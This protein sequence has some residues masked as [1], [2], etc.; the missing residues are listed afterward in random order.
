MAKDP[1]RY[2]RI[3]AREIVE[4][5]SRGV[6][7]LEQGPPGKEAVGRLLRLAHTLKG[8]AHVVK[9]AG[10]AGLAHQLEDGLAPYASGN[11]VAS[12]DAE[13]MLRLVDGMAEQ[14]A[15]FPPAPLD[16]SAALAEPTAVPVPSASSVSSP[17]LSGNGTQAAPPPSGDEV[18][19]TVRVDLGDMDVLLEGLAETGVKLAGVKAKLA[20]LEQAADL[21]ALQLNQ[22]PTG[23]AGTGGARDAVAW[24]TGRSIAEDLHKLLQPLSRT[25]AAEVEQ[26]EREWALARD[27]ATQLRLVPA[28]AVF[29]PLRHMARETANALE[30]RVEFEANGGEHRL[31]AHVLSAMRDALLQIVR[32]AVAHGIETPAERL[33]AGKPA[34]GR[35]LMRVQ[36]RGNRIAFACED[37]GRGFDVARL[38][39]AGVRAGLLSETEAAAL[40]SEELFRLLLRGGI[41]TSEKV[42]QMAGRGLGLGVVQEAVSRL[43]AEI[44]LR[45]QPGRGS[46][47]EI[48]VPVSMLSLEA[49]MVESGGVGASLPL[50]AVRRTLRL[51]AG[52]V[53]HGPEGDRVV[54]EGKA[55]PF[56]HLGKL[57]RQPPREPARP[58]RF[59]PAVVVHSGAQ[60]AVIGVE[61]LLGTA[62]VLLRPIPS[63]AGVHPVVAGAALDAQGNPQLVLDPAALVAAADGGREPQTAPGTPPRIPLIL[64]IDDSLTTR[65][66][67][68]SILESA[69]YEVAL[70]TSGEEAL[71]KARERAYD[72][73]LVDVEM[74]GMDGFE[75]IAQTRSDPALSAAPCILV[76]SRGSEEDKRRGEAVGAR[77]Y[78]VK[79]EFNQNQLLRTIRELAG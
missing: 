79:N 76:T 71:Q 22:W 16:P 8:A 74:P 29:A 14:L 49:V 45:N 36:R 72:L 31:D 21:A 9:Q 20:G 30:K 50:D 54:L 64:V 77:A 68:Q 11:A 25:L 62:R 60:H 65:M 73:F 51:S 38:R 61:A 70:A 57:L 44:A 27:H 17:A 18:F 26:A 78:F 2:F 53:V 6:L 7:D 33:A 19:D 32:N 56:L 5:L 47:L 75:F 39:R 43:K 10:I 40:G 41:S 4:Q 12:P 46:T 13:A 28:S 48:L 3:E 34:S 67:E 52:E 58:S 69:G 24:S 42:T 66:L 15:A 35:V 23:K 59:S 63:F 55:I 1:Y 37:D